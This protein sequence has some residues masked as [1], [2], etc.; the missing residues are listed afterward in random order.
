MPGDVWGVGAVRRIAGRRAGWLARVVVARAAGGG[1]T[2]ARAAILDDL[3]IPYDMPD[4]T[5]HGS[6]RATLK[7]PDPQSAATLC[8]KR[9]LGGPPL[10]APPS[11]NLHHGDAFAGF[12]ARWLDVPQEV[13]QGDQEKVRTEPGDAATAFAQKAF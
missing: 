4:L 7:G 12:A 11:Q 3:V 1:R 8:V 5:A 6:R 13:C 2:T 10:S 9:Q